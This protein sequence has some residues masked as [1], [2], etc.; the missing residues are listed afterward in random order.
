MLVRIATF[1]LHHGKEKSK[2]YSRAKML[3]DIESLN[4]DIICLQEADVFSFRTVFDNQPKIIAEHLGYFYVSNRVRFFGLGFQHNAIISKFPIVNSEAIILP[5]EK[6]KQNR[7]ALNA[8]IRIEEKDV[9]LITTHLNTDGSLKNMNLTARNQ[10]KF[11]VEIYAEK[12]AVIAGDL[13]L[14]SEYVFPIIN[15]AGF[16][17]IDNH[18][19][20]PA[21]EPKHQIDWIIARGYKLSNFEVSPQLCSDHRALLATLEV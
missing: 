11:L 5:T 21:R 14:T 12:D 6:S 18:A 8:D 10:L 19:T 7:V 13:N 15:R 20:S 1:N 3:K 17:T 16:S 4:A 2:R 9:T